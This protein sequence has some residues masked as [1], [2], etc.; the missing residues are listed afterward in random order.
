MKKQYQKPEVEYI[1][2][3]AEEAIAEIFN[4]EFGSAEI[5]EDWE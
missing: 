3:I 1:S 4:G 5:P 2:L